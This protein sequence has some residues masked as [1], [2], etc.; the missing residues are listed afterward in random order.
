MLTP[1]YKSTTDCIHMACAPPHGQVICAE[2]PPRGM[3]LGVFGATGKLGTCIVRQA[4]ENKHEVRALV[5]DP[6]RLAPD[7]KDRIT[8]IEGDAL[9]EAD[10]S[11][12]MEG[13]DHVLFALGVDRRSPENLCTDCTRLILARIGS[14]RLIW[15]GGGANLVEG[16]SSLGML[17]YLI[18]GPRFVRWYAA[19]FLARRHADKTNQMALFKSP[20]GDACE[21]YGIRPL[22]MGQSGVKQVHT[23]QYRLGMH[24]FTGL[25][26]ISFADCADAMLT[27]LTDDTWRHRC[28]IVQ[29]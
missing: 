5:R 17:D 26:K 29:Y 21:W 15:C 12:V 24:W 11:A 8:V 20:E 1:N 18:V 10:V 16:D 22:Q 9:S 28:P 14:R 7:I 27:M 23:G 6:S 25:S 3:I 4:L 2:A 19:T 13:T